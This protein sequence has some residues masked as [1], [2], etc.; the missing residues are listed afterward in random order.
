MTRDADA[1]VSAL[2]ASGVPFRHLEVAAADLDTAFLA[3]T[4][5]RPTETAA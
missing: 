3:L 5:A 4:S 1:T 2:V